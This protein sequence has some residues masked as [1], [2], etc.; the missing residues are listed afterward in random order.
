MLA[1]M[2]GIVIPSPPILAGR[3]NRAHSKSLSGGLPVSVGMSLRSIRT[4]V[5]NT[6]IRVRTYALWAGCNGALTCV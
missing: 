4:Y 2:E 1:C 5:G 6:Y 3:A